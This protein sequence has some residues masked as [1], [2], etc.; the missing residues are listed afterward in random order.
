MGLG[1]FT[2]EINMICQTYKNFQKGNARVIKR[3]ESQSLP[4]FI[5]GSG[6]SITEL[7]PF[8]EEHQEKAVIFRP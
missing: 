6:P 2:D 3:L 1:F 4:A 5:I 8:I 7:L